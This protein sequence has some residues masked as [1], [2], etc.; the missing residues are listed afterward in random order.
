MTIRFPARKFKRIAEKVLE[1]L[2][3]K[4]QRARPKLEE[5][6]VAPRTPVEERLATIWAQTLGI[7]QVGIH[8]NFFQMGGHS[9]IG[10]LLISRVF[11]AFQTDLSLRHLFES[12]TVA[13]L[14][15]VINQGQVEQA[16]AQEV[17]A[18]LKELDEL[19]DEQVMALLA[20]EED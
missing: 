9:L 13:G 16:S 17:A 14:A 6:Y 7:S 11:D 18:A 2:E 20:N 4:K 19:S 5:A 8:D 15:Q 3:A 10:T 1:V 12:P